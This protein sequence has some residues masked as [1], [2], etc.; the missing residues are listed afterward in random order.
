MTLALPDAVLRL[1]R[2]VTGQFPPALLRLTD[3]AL[4]A[5]LQAVDPTPDTPLGSGTEDWA[6]LPDRMHFIADLFRTRHE[7]A[8][9]HRPPFSPAQLRAIADG[10]TSDG[11]F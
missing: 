11:D 5:F 1:G 6:L 2:D 7:D 4:T 9:L 10:R 3:P 8:T